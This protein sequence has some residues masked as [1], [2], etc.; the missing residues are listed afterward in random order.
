MFRKLE[1]ENLGLNIN[2]SRMKHV[3]FA[4]DLVLFEEDPLLLEPMVQALA[5]KTREVGLEVNSS[6]T[7]I[8]TNFT[9]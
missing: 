3:R 2:G 7:K 6:K 1:W 9:L 4:D 5:E 8:M